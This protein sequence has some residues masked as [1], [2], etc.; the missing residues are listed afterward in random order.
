[1]YR[2]KNPVV[3]LI[4]V[5]LIAGS[6]KKSKKDLSLTAKEY[7]MKGMP[8][9]DKIW[10]DQDY[11]NA[12]NTLGSL[13]VSNFLSLP[14]KHSN[15]SGAV[16]SRI[17]NKEN[18]SFLNDSTISLRDKAFRI[19][20]FSSFLNELSR[21]YTDNLKKEQ[22][23]DEELIDIH[24]FELFVRKKM[25]E[26][27]GKIMNSK[28]KEDIS[29]QSGTKAIVKG[30]LNLVSAVLREQVKT[31]IFP[32]RDLKRLSMEVSNSLMENLSWIEP[33]DRQK[34]SV[35]VQNTIDKSPSGSV[36]KNYGK[37]LKLLKE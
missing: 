22:Y 20:Y 36:K 14:R 8:E 26:L 7:Q 31:E 25:L 3:I 16:F 37:I 19:Q 33:A 13:R 34:I 4:L 29:M 27:A 23:Y 11:I 10:S 32:A 6:C 24:I 17:I 30:Y 35:E 1:M 2:L 12:H 15:K 28:E 18:L 5:M 21:M 9:N